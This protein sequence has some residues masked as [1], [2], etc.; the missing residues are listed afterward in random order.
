M[1]YAV[2]GIHYCLYLSMYNECPWPPPTQ[3]V[4]P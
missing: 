3:L 4:R 1:S 2:N